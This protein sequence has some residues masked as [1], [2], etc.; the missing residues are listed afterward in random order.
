MRS[1]FLSVFAVF[2]LLSGPAWAGDISPEANREFMA[3]FA[4]KPGAVVLPAF[5]LLS[6]YANAEPVLA[7][8]FV[9]LCAEVKL[10]HSLK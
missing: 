10:F 1:R 4:K 9:V 8:S 2:A 7:I 5:V 3:A 6:C